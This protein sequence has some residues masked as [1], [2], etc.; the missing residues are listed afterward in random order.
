MRISRN[1]L[2]GLINEE[3][4]RALL[5]K[6]NRRLVE[7]VSSY[8]DTG[9]GSLYD[10][11]ASEL[12]DFAKSYASLGNAIQEQLDELLDEQ[13]DASVNPNAVQVM[14]ERLGGM[15]AEIDAAIEAW[16][17]AGTEDEEDDG[18]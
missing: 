18:S 8:A 11:E 7:A 14:E 13:E 15:N 16:R 9:H 12:L 5:R 6:E 4:S 2:Q 10:I 17:A 3:I 1:E